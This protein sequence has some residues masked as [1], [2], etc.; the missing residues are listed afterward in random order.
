[1]SSYLKILQFLLWENCSN[2][3]EFCLFKDGNFYN[4]E[5][6]I[7]SIDNAISIIKKKETIDKYDGVGLI[8]GEVLE[9]QTPDVE[10]KWF[11]LIDYINS[12]EYKTVWL[13]TSLLYKDNSLLH[14]TINR[15]KDVHIYLCTSF[16]V[17]GRFNEI[18]KENWHK[19]IASIDY[20]N[21][22]IHTSIILNDSLIDA[23]NNHKRLLDNVPNFSFIA[24]QLNATEHWGKDLKDYN[25]LLR[26]L[27][28]TY[29]PGF[30]IKNR[31][32]LLKFVREFF[33]HYGKNILKHS[34]E[35]KT[36]SYDTIIPSRFSEDYYKDKWLS[37]S[38][39][40]LGCGHENYSKFY[41]DSDKCV[42]C[43]IEEV[44]NCLE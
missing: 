4:E 30:F 38:K 7:S 36:H 16:D 8:G 17:E 32:V 15:L 23:F 21:V 11:E 24:P 25:S 39:F 40:N 43:D 41:L 27:H 31:S 20:D 14:E 13:A 44:L 12:S 22:T 28:N 10:S 1:M 19:N 6:K 3:C 18:K 5:E 29:H 9:R 34:I 37:S 26:E 42:F 35:I 33:M 2:G